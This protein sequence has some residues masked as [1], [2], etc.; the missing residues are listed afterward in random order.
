[1]VVSGRTLLLAVKTC[2]ECAEEFACDVA[3]EAAADLAV[4][5]AFGSATFEVGPSGRVV[6]LSLDGDDVQSAVE[7]PVATAV[8]AM[9]RGHPG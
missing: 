5:S 3:L 6:P 7:L 4:G 8:E 2:L 9:A 1:M